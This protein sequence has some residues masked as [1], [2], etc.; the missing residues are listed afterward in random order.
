MYVCMQACVHACICTGLYVC[1]SACT[2][3]CAWN[4]LRYYSDPFLR[5]TRFIQVRL[6]RLLVN[7]FW[8]VWLV[9]GSWATATSQTCREVPPPHWAYPTAITC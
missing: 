1:L 7:V 6:T 8:I 3:V 4:T 5:P 2:I 9:V